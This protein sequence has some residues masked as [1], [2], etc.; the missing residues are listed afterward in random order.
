[1]KSVQEAIVS[2]VDIDEDGNKILVAF[3]KRNHLDESVDD[4][5]MKLLDKLP[6]YMIPNVFYFIESFPLTNNGKVDRKK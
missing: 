2:A 5:K 1:M 6:E 3:C 4:I